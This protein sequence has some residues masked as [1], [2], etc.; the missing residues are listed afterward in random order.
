MD[1]FSLNMITRAVF[2]FFFFL[3][4]ALQSS[5]LRAMTTMDR[6]YQLYGC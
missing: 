6:V 5:N 3:R 2:A 4:P 1:L